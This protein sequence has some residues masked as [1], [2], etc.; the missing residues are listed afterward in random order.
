ME[1]SGLFALPN[2]FANSIPG[3]GTSTY[4]V[5]LGSYGTFTGDLADYSDQIAV[6]KTVL[7][8]VFSF[9]SIR[10]VMLRR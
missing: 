7:L 1:N 4:T 2:E 6:V 3:G 9:L 5:D 10:V 8:L